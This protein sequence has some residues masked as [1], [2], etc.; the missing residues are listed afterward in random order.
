MPHVN[1][2]FIKLYTLLILI[3]ATPPIIVALSP[4]KT[5]SAGCIL[6]AC[7]GLALSLRQS[8]HLSTIKNRTLISLSLAL[9]YF[10]AQHIFVGEWQAKSY[11]S[12]LALIGMFG[13][14]YLLAREFHQ[15]DSKIVL[16]AFTWSYYSFAFIGIFNISTFYI[17]GKTLGYTHA[18]PFFPFLEPSH[19]ALYFGP[20]SFIYV[21]TQTTTIKQIYAISLLFGMGV[22]T[23]NTTLLTYASLSVLLLI[24]SLRPKALFLT[25]PIF[26]ATVIYGSSFV[27]S[28]E[29]FSSRLDLS[30]DNQSATTLVYLQGVQDAV[31]SLSST[32]G[33]GLGFQMLGTQPPSEYAYSIAKVMADVN[34]ELN[35]QDG[36]FLAAKLIAEL[37]VLG[38]V[39]L[40]LFMISS[41]KS[42]L[43]VR[44]IKFKSMNSQ[45]TKELIFNCIIITFCIEMFIRGYGYFSSGF[46]LFLIAVF[47]LAHSKSNTKTIA[48]RLNSFAYN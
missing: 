25:L 24:F 16:E 20:L 35:R 23:P 47:Y 7:I 17:L 8:K 38:I 11:I 5:F 12:A 21:A 33:L 44:H 15:I 28:N 42:L 41:T 31:N 22:I 43:R 27:L 4:I 18:K 40:I 30:A 26:L 3:G 46:F 13:S 45:N 9:T 14:A 6:I 1:Q 39:L 2:N 19:F 32:N 48:R 36:G 37:G 34:G 29:Y 10:F